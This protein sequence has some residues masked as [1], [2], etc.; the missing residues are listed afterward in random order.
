MSNIGIIDLGSN[1]ARL[2]VVS[3]LKDGSYKIIDDIKESVRLGKDIQEDG[4][5]NENRV[6]LAIK[7]LENFKDVCTSNNVEE[8][9]AVA[10][11]AVRVA[12]DQKEFIKK[13]KDIVGIDLRVLSG[14]EEAFYDYFGIVN[15]LDFNNGLIMDIGGASTEVI[16]VN[17][18]G[19]KEALSLPFGAITL[20]ERFKLNDEINEENLSELRK[21]LIEHYRTIP[22]LANIKNSA[23]VGVGGTIRNIGKIHRRQKNY[24]FEHTHNYRIDKEDVI[25]ITNMVGT[26]N[27]KQRKKIKGLSKS[28]ADI[29]VAACEAVKALIEYCEVKELIVSETGV[30]EGLIYEI[31]L[32]KRVAL[33]DVLESSI[34]NLMQKYEVNTR[35]A[36]KVWKLAKNIYDD[37]AP[38]YNMDENIL[39][40]L[41]TAA[42]LYEIGM[43]INCSGFKKHSF[44]LI[45]N[46]N[47]NGLSQ[48]EI[49]MVAYT[50]L[51]FQEDDFTGLTYDYRDILSDKDIMITQK[52]GVVL[53]IA[54][55]LHSK[56]IED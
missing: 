52:L 23:L 1:S 10:T 54:T 39:K 22:W 8:I 28:R 29:F 36:N 13:V 5:L 41:K 11:A 47:L 4:R 9:Y 31:I 18:R 25:E 43:H 24:S 20:T 2:L 12:K 53:K 7:T 46:S 37:S 30:K 50:I 19:I 56:L 34:K 32:G 16:C 48:R 6:E 35:R 17:E 40:I 21:Y 27:L 14:E 45:L 49:L 38:L 15:T 3:L 44:Y 26:L 42:M 55:N 51:Y 33:E